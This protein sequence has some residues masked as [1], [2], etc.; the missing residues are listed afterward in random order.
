LKNFKNKFAKFAVKFRQRY[1][2]VVGKQT[3]I[4]RAEYQFI[5]ILP[6]FGVKFDEVGKI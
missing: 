1:A 3:K 2:A 4:K 5:K 6:A